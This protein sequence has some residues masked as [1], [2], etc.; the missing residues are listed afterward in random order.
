MVTSESDNGIS[1]ANFFLEAQ[2]HFYI[3]KHIVFPDYFLFGR[4]KSN[5]T[6]TVPEVSPVSLYSMFDIFPL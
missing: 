5:V 2:T 6:S 3:S 4:K 1:R